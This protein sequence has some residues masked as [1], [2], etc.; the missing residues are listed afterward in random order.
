[1]D[2][3]KKQTSILSYWTFRYLLI[4]CIGLLVI[5]IT[6][7]CWIRQE[8]M[9]NRLQTTALLAQEIADR[10]VNPDGSIVVGESLRELIE[11]RKRFFKMT[12]EMCVIV[13]DNKGKMLFSMPKLTQEDLLHKLDD[14]LNE[15][16]SP[17]FKAAKAH[18]EYGGEPIGQ[19][20]LLQAKNEL[21]YIPTEEKWFFAIMLVSLAS[22][23]WLT[24]YLLSRKLTRPIR[25]VVDAAAQISRGQYD[26][27]LEADANEREINELLLSFQQMAGRLKRLEHSR[28]IM[29]AGVSHELKTPVTSIKGLVHAVRENVVN[30]EEADEFLDIALLE[31]DRLQRMVADLLDY[32]ALAAGIVQVRHEQLAAIPL[33]SEIVYQ[34]KL[35]QGEHVDE[36]KLIM[37]TKPFNLMGDPLRIQ[38]IIVNLLNNSVHAKHPNRTVHI[39]IELI[40]HPNGSAEV[41]VTD[42]G[43][44][45]CTEDQDFVFE[46]FFRS[47]N[48]KN[49][50]RGLGLG[51]TFSRLLAGAMGGDVILR[52]SS[53]KGSSFVLLLPIHD[54][55]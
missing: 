45:I 37:P 47:G 24:I 3:I 11:N 16:R 19:V 21:K 14:E 30:G 27:R 50:V 55:L 41:I 1:M 53:E 31:T 15:S 39:Q 23:S 7:I 4:L 17:E 51:L 13:T 48:Q 5:A 10:I 29:L 32:N 49:R 43:N 54:I 9:N 38:Q 36:P 35:T 12:N 2:R 40:E 8:S 18:I 52:N 22:L 44:G 46:R 20:T 28:A 26:I 25:R 6:S 42:N 34:W 33:I